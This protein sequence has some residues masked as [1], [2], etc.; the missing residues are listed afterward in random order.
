MGNMIR[1]LQDWQG[2]YV[3]SFNEKLLHSMAGEYGEID[4]C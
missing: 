2:S 3:A 1:S 4:K